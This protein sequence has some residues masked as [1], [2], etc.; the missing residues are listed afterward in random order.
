MFDK[1]SRHRHRRA[2]VCRYTPHCALA[3]S[4]LYGWVNK[5]L[6]DRSSEFSNWRVWLFLL[7][8]PRTCPDTS[9]RLFSTPDVTTPAANSPIPN[10]VILMVAAV[11][12]LPGSVKSRDESVG[13]WHPKNNGLLPIT[14]HLTVSI[15]WWNSIA[16]CRHSEQ[17]TWKM[18]CKFLWET[19]SWVGRSELVTSRCASPTHRLRE[20]HRERR[21]A[22]DGCRFPCCFPTVDERGKQSAF[23]PLQTLGQANAP[24]FPTSRSSSFLRL[25]HGMASGQES[26]DFT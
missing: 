3:V 25:A 7:N 23:S 17:S 6:S 21:G 2:E 18:G 12:A 20:G 9:R 8:T 26:P 19:N 16:G 14:H 22:E 4:R 1:L 15:T 10:V 11:T 5:A 13:P 24:S